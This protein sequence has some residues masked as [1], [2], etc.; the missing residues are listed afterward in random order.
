[1]SKVSKSGPMA[2]PC[3][4]AAPRASYLRE[5]HYIVGMLDYPL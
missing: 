1:M 5:A 4:N 3:R 2:S